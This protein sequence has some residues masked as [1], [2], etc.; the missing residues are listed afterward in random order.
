MRHAAPEEEGNCSPPGQHGTDPDSLMPSDPNP[1][2]CHEEP[3]PLGAIGRED[4][5]HHNDLGVV[6]CAQP[7]NG[8]K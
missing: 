1:D 3:D 4:H 2:S 6:S 8:Q 7:V 5:H